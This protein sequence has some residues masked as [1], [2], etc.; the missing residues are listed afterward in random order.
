MRRISFVFGSIVIEADLLDTPTADAIWDALPIEAS[1][2]TWGD[3]VYFDCG[4]ALAEEPDA[5]T[6]MNPGDIAYWPPGDAIAIGFGRTPASRGD[7]IRL[8]SEANVWARTTDDVTRLRP[9]RSG[10]RVRI[11]KAHATT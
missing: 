3:E 1:V 5:R 2:S 11:V 9:V 6:L 10:S 4:V 7:E 8:A